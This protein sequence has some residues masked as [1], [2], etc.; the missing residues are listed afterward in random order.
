MK[1]KFK[2]VGY[3]NFCWEAECTGEV[4]REWLFKQVKPHCMS[5]NLDFDY[6]EET[7]HGTIYAGFRAIGDFY[8]KVK[9]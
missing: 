4:T 9:E 1:V 3:G 7:G 6:N 8:L 2:D 5:R